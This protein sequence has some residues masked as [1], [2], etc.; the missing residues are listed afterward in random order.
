MTDTTDQHA[1][2][3]EL[4]AI[5]RELSAVLR[6]EPAG[7]VLGAH[8]AL[9]DDL[10]VCGILGGK[11]V[12]K[13]TL[14]N[15]L[16]QTEVSVDKTEVGRGTDRPMA[17]VH[18]A[19]RDTLTHRLQANDNRVPLDVTLH[20]A[21]AVRNAV[22]IDLPDFDSDFL[23]HLETVRRLIPFLD[24]ILWVLTPRKIGDRA[25]VAMFRDVV[26][27]PINVHC[28][29]NKVDELLADSDPFGPRADASLEGNGRRAERFWGEQHQWVAQSIEAVGCPANEEHRFLVAAAFPD[30]DRFVSR[31]RHL[32]DDPDWARYGADQ[33]AVIEVARR[34][35]DELERL[36]SR[37]LAPVSHEQTQ[38]LKEANRQR[39]LQVNVARMKRHY[40]LDRVAEQLAQACDPTYLQQ[41][42]NEAMGPDFSEAVAITVTARMRRDAELADEMLERRVEHWP[43][44][45][46]VHWPFGWLARTLGRRVGPASP[47]AREEPDDPFG[48]G[49]RLL[50]DRIELVRSRLLGDRAVIARKLGVDAELP[51]SDRLATAVAASVRRLPGQLETRLLDDV[52]EHARKPSLVGRAALWLILLWFPFLQPI[53]AGVLEIFAETGTVQLAHGLYRIVSALSAV[54]LLSGFAVVGGVYVAILAAMYVRGLRA[55]R[56]ARYEHDKTSPVVDAI[57]EILLSEVVLPL[58]GPFQE[59]LERLKGL[60]SRLQVGYQVVEDHG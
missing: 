47:T 2:E 9:G 44:L 43:L 13:S 32:W 38:A 49:G 50:T 1:I 12:G 36:R 3:S 39:E 59:R 33:D 41:A 42:V 35:S 30:Q 29:L 16:A 60:C 4:G 18:E 40:D 24:R 51:A 58:A 11:D 19:M 46:L 48:P 27:D 23:E 31:I 37:V 34:A 8:L 26:K 53:L 17:Y 54:H 52:S 6:T 28:V 20:A 14:I 22:L 21:D 45:R 7:L 25:W 57:D 15:A 55:V 5:N 10:A 56:T